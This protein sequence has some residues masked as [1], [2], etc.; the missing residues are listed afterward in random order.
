MRED[1]TSW[2]LEINRNLVRDRNEKNAN[3][4]DGE[5]KWKVYRNK[6]VQ[7]NVKTQ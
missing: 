5:E 2:E 7:G 6:L 4:K 1:M 3:L